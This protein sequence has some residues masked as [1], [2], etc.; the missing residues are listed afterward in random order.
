MKN[1]DSFPAFL[2]LRNLPVF[3]LLIIGIGLLQQCQSDGPF[4]IRDSKEDVT[5]ST[6]HYLLQIQKQGFKYQF[7]LPNGKVIAPFHAASGLLLGE[8]GEKPSAVSSTTLVH[9]TEVNLEFEVETENGSVS[10]VII[11]PKSHMLK[12]EVLPAKDA[13]YSIL[14]R[15]GGLRTSLWN[16]GSCC[17][18]RRANR[19]DAKRLCSGS[20]RRRQRCTAN[21][22]QFCHIPAAGICRSEYGA[23]QFQDRSNYQ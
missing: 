21:D 23:K 8:S 20:H 1:S 10:R 6:E 3:I 13:E 4:T 18:W 19:S 17:L 9:S 22:Q 14:A 15:T 16:G 5:I 2:V 7:S 12:M 11:Y